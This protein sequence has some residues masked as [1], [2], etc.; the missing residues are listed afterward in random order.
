MCGATLL[1]RDLSPIQSP[2]L[3]LGLQILLKAKG[4]TWCARGTGWI[5][6][7]LVGPWVP[8]NSGLFA[9]LTLG[10]PV[11]HLTFGPENLGDTDKVRSGSQLH[12]G[13]AVQGAGHPYWKSVT[14]F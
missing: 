12:V 11:S 1:P 3:H 13:M 5:L 4:P 9:A 8:W 7:C 6:T 2:K 10:S 14:M